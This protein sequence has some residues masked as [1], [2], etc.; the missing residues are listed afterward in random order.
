[1]RLKNILVV[2]DDPRL[3]SNI[4][5]LLQAEGYNTHSASNGFE[6]LNYI[7]EEIPDLIISDI[8]MPMMDGMELIKRIQSNSS[9]ASIPFIFLTAKVQAFDIR[10]GMNLG[11]DDYITKPFKTTELLKAVSVRL[12]K[13][14]NVIHH[15]EEM[16][17]DIAAK[18]PH[19]LRTPLVSIFG[20]SDIILDE[21]DNLPKDEIKSYIKIIRSAGEKIHERIEKFL[22]YTEVEL[23]YNGI[24][25]GEKIKN[26][27]FY[28]NQEEIKWIFLDPVRD[29]GR[30]DDLLISIDDCK[31]GMA[32]NYLMIIIKE[33]LDN[34]VKFSKPA[35]Q[36]KL[37]GSCENVYYRIVV[38][39][40]GC[41][42]NKRDIERIEPFRQFDR[43][44]YKREGVGL[45]LAI[46][47]KILEIF[48][49]HM[50]IHS[51]TDIGTTV[52]ALI[53]AIYKVRI[54]DKKY[55]LHRT[56]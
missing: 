13:K 22:I 52:T 55:K 38:S 56:N 32:K 31:I 36:I 4:S 16:K 51:R 53:P 28:I 10:H 18:I 35:T 26:E 20:Y 1:M 45:G 42:M 44:D 40:E 37:T 49:G 11:A 34:A 43:K 6:A 14:E 17:T 48:K 47:K 46:V 24:E 12:K 21:I 15:F 19:E 41:G 9:T 2:E 27:T 5:E 50:S 39:D 54:E 33:L 29:M 3:K 25:H 30:G 8:M 7:R 23:L